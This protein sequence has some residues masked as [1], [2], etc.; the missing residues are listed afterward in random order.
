[1]R[2]IITNLLSNAIKFSPEGSVITIEIKKINSQ[3][4]IKVKD[5]GIGIP[6]D[7]MDKIYEPFIRADNVQQINGT[8]FGLTVVKR[9]VDLL[10]GEILCSSVI[11]EGTIFSVYLPLDKRQI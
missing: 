9:A 2:H 6:H 8:G 7:Y 3:I 5:N 11:N 1:M 10:G 4:A